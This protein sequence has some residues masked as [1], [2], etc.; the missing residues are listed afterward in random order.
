[1][2]VD[3]EKRQKPRD[4]GDAH[5]GRM[6]L[7]RLIPPDDDAIVVAPLASTGCARSASASVAPRLRSHKPDTDSQWTNTE[8]RRR[9]VSREAAW[10][11]EASGKG[12]SR[13]RSPENDCGNEGWNATPLGGRAEPAS[14]VEI[15]T[16]AGENRAG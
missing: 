5:L 3:G 16:V 15:P 8:R 12:G 10:H 14:G 6:R 4:V 1:M 2:L 13:T 7:D 9:R 11:A